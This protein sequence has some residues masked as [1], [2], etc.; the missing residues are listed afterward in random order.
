MTQPVVSIVAEGLPRLRDLVGDRALRTRHEEFERLGLPL[1][2][3]TERDL[4]L[5]ARKVSAESLR[6]AYQSLLR[7]THQFL[8]AAYEIRAAAMLAPFVDAIELSPKVGNARCD[9]RCR[10]QGADLFVEVSA[11]TDAFPPRYDGSVYARATVD[12]AFDPTSK[13][14]EPSVRSTPA[15]TEL[16]QRI[17][18]ELRQLPRDG[19]TMLVLGAKEGH[20]LDLE[21]ALWGDEIIVASSE[22]GWRHERVANG[23]FAIADA[24]GGVSGLSAVAWLKLSSHFSDV[25][26]RSRLFTNP[27]ART[28]VSP[29]L[30]SALCQVFDRRAVLERECA[31]IVAAL[32]ESYRPERVILFGS[33]AAESR[34]TVH[35]WSDIDLA[36]VKQTPRMFVERS[37][38]VVDLVESRVSLNVFVYTP[39]EFEHAAREPRSFVRT[40]IVEKGKTLFSRT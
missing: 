8:D 23:L 38:E 9:M 30:E 10:I 16:R 12:K 34:D 39:D 18:D 14:G 32:L 29:A 2:W 27:R 17:V 24:G 33:L 6:R 28:A 19:L 25:V 31:R 15:A 20:S 5:L 1:L 11:H 3:Q 22:T 36:V 7:N 13:A 26:T 37:R 21:A 35:Q 40:E 4:H